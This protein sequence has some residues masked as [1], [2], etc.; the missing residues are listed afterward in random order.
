MTNPPRPAEANIRRLHTWLGI[1]AAYVERYT[2][3]V[4]GDR[5]AKMDLE[6]IRALLSDI[7]KPN[8]RDLE[9]GLTHIRGD[10]T[11]W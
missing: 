5:N 11:D 6:H 7:E 9:A 2:R 10:K 4:P 1:A 3:L 8:D